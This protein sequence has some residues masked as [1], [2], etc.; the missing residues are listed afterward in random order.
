MSH[1]L[2]AR[3]A[4]RPA[5]RAFTLIE[6]LVVIAIIAILAAILFPVFA[7]A[8]EK[9]RQASCM[10]NI[11]QIGIATMMYTQDYD[12]TLF[13]WMLSDPRGL[14]AW[15]GLT[16]FSAGFPPKYHPEQGL[17]QP[18]MKNTLVEDCPTANGLAPFAV[19]LANGVPVWVAYGVNMLLMPAQSGS[20]GL[21]YTGMSMARAQSP[22]NT[23]FLADAVDFGYTPMGKLIRCSR[24]APQ[25]SNSPTMHGRHN[26]MANTLWL[27]G[28]VKAFKPMIPTSVGHPAGVG[29]YQ[30]NN[31]GYLVAPASVSSNPDYYFVLDK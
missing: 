8:R 29:V 25:S 28:H 22:A 5:V 21:V 12:E 7:Q 16:D 20:S 23:V 13:P 14:L 10:S 6:L 27:D 24:L 9:A 15:D 30:A 1:V 4:A 19:D 2:S 11:R 17:L 18:Y 3:K 31:V 26:G